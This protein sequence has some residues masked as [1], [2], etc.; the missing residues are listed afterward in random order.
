[1]VAAIWSLFWLRCCC[2][3]VALCRLDPAVVVVDC[4]GG[5]C[6]YRGIVLSVDAL[7][8]GKQLCGLVVVETRGCASRDA[9]LQLL[10]DRRLL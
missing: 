2:A 5:R 7:T 4:C 3:A 9:A 8:A 6:H 10:N 1:M